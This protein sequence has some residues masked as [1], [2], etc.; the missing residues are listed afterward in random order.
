[1]TYKPVVLVLVNMPVIGCY[2][3]IL[4][5]TGRVADVISFT[6]DYLL[7][8]IQMVEGAIQYDCKISGKSYILVIRN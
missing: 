1:M 3:Y 8:K 2:A 4:S 7:M 6:P 5:D